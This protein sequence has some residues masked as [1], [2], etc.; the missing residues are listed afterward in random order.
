MP[1]LLW[2]DDALEDMMSIYV[3]IG[4]NNA[5]AAERMYTNL[6]ARAKSLIMYP[7]LGVRRRELMPWARLLIEGNYFIF[8]RTHPDADLGSVDAVEIMR[9]VQGNQ[10]LSRVL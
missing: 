5:E 1:K 10:D 3:F 6:E 9:V 8:Y 7:R 4:V 2:S